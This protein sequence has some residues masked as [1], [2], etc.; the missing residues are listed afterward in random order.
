MEMSKMGLHDSFDYFKH[1]LWPKE[2][3]KNQ[4]VNLTMT[5]KSQDVP[6][7]TYV[8]VVWHILLESSQKGL[9]LCFQPHIKQR[10]SQEIMALQNA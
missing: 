8:Q 3:A 7:N 1:K 6:W 4:S 10:S 5:T 2:V 9:Q